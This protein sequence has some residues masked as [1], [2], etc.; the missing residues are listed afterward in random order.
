MERNNKIYT[1]KGGME[2]IK[3]GDVMRVTNGFPEMQHSKWLETNDIVTVTGIYPHVIL[4][5]KVKEVN[6]WHLRQCF[7]RRRWRDYLEEVEA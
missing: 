2:M 7:Q 3:V 4:V 1:Q 5:E 6:G